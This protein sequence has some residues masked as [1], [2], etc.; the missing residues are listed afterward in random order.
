M[1]GQV[2]SGLI[3]LNTVIGEELDKLPGIGPALAGRIIDYREENNGFINVEEIKLVSGIGDKM[4]E[5]I[6]DLISI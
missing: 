4:W 2:Q 1:N 5:K 3:N 6:K